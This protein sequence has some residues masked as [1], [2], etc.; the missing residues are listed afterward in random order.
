M[1]QL[2]NIFN[3]GVG[4][5]EDKLLLTSHN[6]DDASKIGMVQQRLSILLIQAA[7]S[8]YILLYSFDIEDMDYRM[9]RKRSKK[10][11]QTGQ[12]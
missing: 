12:K 9:I 5:K 11:Q 8:T 4:K 10:K 2:Y 6:D 3:T 7:R 1:P